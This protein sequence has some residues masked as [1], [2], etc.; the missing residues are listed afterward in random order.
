MR[1]HKKSRLGKWKWLLYALAL[2]VIVAGAGLGI[3]IYALGYSSDEI[4]S[5]LE[6]VP[7]LSWFLPDAELKLARERITQLESRLEEAQSLL[8]EQK[9]MIEMMEEDLNQK[10][11]EIAQ[12][13]QQ[14]VELS[15]QLEEQLFEQKA[16]GEHLQELAKLYASMSASRAAGIL[17]HLSLSETAL[18]LREMNADQKS[19]IMARMEPQYAAN[20]TLVLKEMEQ[21]SNP[22]SASSQERLMNL[23]DSMNISS[24]N[25]E[26][27]L[28]ITHL[29]ATFEQINTSEAAQILSGMEEKRTQFN[30]GRAILASMED[31]FRARVLGAMKPETAQAYIEALA[32]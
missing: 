3:L 23:L 14:N 29:A 30:L 10:D 11:E 6:E 18:I 32:Q 20:L 12:L 26:G 25:A 31:G 9:I 4:Q 24:D 8:A 19:R 21:V 1:E 22:D 15:A 13:T 5:I 2:A 27:K 7:V 17:E 28:S 16:R